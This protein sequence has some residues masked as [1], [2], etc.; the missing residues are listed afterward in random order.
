MV[1]L[2]THKPLVKPVHV[3]ILQTPSE[4]VSQLARLDVACELISR[5]QDYLQ[6][7]TD[8]HKYL[9]IISNG[10]RETGIDSL[11]RL[12]QAGSLCPETHTQKNKIQL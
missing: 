11:A 3:V 5:D 10:F 1:R 8:T 9:H 6:T 2:V 12:E 7:H 4:L